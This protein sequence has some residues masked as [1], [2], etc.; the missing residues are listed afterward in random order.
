MGPDSDSRAVCLSGC[1]TMSYSMDPFAA[2]IIYE[3]TGFTG[4]LGSKTLQNS[5]D[6]KHASLNVCYMFAS[7]V[8]IGNGGSVHVRTATAACSSTRAAP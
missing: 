8:L 1:C 4:V 3:I 5:K 2:S 6:I 7:S